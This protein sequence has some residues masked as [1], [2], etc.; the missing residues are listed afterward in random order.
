MDLIST[1]LSLTRLCVGDLRLGL[2]SWF[3]KETYNYHE[4][5]RD[6]MSWRQVVFEC[7]RED[8]LPVATCT[9][10]YADMWSY[11]NHKTMLVLCDS[12]RQGCLSPE[13][14]W[15]TTANLNAPWLP[16][17]LRPN[18]YFRLNFPG[19]YLILYILYM[20]IITIMIVYT[21]VCGVTF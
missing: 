12:H 7:E 6:G 16:L 19:N 5:H 10:L 13:V 15:A 20:T 11:L 9:H 4:L 3:G 14:W 1:I 21:G 8:S 17:Q 18:G 2:E